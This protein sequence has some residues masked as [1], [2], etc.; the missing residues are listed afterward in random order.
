MLDAGA[1]AENPLGDSHGR[2]SYA[3]SSVSPQ[4]QK[5]LRVLYVSLYRLD[6]PSS[7]TSLEMS[8]QI[9]EATASEGTEFSLV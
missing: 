2:F 4:H 1:S 6:S 3:V 9:I 5:T 8:G 7:V